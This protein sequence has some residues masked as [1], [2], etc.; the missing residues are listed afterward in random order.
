METEFSLLAGW[1]IDGTGTPAAGDMLI[2]IEEGTIASLDHFPFGLSSFH[3]TDL[4]HCTII[5]ALV[6]SHVHLTLSGITDQALRKNQLH[7]TF[8]QDAPLIRKRI[9]KYLSYGILG[10]RDGGDRSADTLRYKMEHLLHGARSG[11]KNTLRD[12]E[13]VRLKTPGS[14]WKANGR[15]GTMIGN[16]PEQGLTLAEAIERSMS[17]VDH[18]KIINSGLNSLI[19]FGKQTPPQFSRGELKAAIQAALK[20]GLKTMIHANGILPVADAIEAGCSSIEHAFFMGSDN[21]RKMADREIF[22]VPTAFSMK[23]LHL[24]TPA[25]MHESEVAARNLDHQM[26]QISRAPSIGVRVALGTDA[27]GFGLHHADSFA[28]EFKV[29]QAAGFSTEMTVRCASMEGAH[30]LG[31]EQEIG[32]IRIGMPATFVVLDGPPSLLP[33]SVRNVRTVY[34]HG[35]PIYQK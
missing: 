20:R 18:V 27:G 26:E 23:A 17:P 4:S 21:M 1:L 28:E 31:L 10:L 6:D 9:S 7:Y 33:D 30:L 8:Q 13:P 3:Y 24:H 16:P 12:E 5:P 25:D 22:W 34:F 19:E 32:T 11:N 35:K 15:Y 14:A 2:R 29:F